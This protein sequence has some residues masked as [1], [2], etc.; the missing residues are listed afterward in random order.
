MDLET[1]LPFALAFLS[2]L[3]F[4]LG[5]AVRRRV[6]VMLP[7]KDP[8]TLFLVILSLSPV[9]C[10]LAGHHIID[11][12]NVWYLAAIVSFLSCY[13]IAYLRGE[14]DMVNIGVWN[15]GDLTG[16]PIVYY[17]G[18]DGR[19]Y[20]QEQSF[21]E[22]LKTVFLG[23]RSPLEFPADIQRTNKVDVQKVLYP[24]ISMDLVYLID[25]EVTESE[26][27]KLRYFRFKV[28]SYRY[29]VAPQNIDPSALWMID[30]EHN[31][32]LM[33]ELSRQEAALFEAKQDAMTGMIATGTDLVV[34]LLGDH[35]PE[36]DVYHD[37]IEKFSKMP[38]RRA[39]G[40]VKEDEED[41]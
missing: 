7:W 13:F 36:S 29:D 32:I 40:P 28:R 23:I 35:T 27:T 34:N 18:P 3:S 33:K 39:K 9:I 12:T 2:I 4:Q 8:C 11:T 38:G 31:R 14:F 30:R 26:V 20:L 19:M 41:D 10:D 37:L 6:H 21:K 17:Y 24:R 15:G 1:V 16:R 25:E 22:I 5:S